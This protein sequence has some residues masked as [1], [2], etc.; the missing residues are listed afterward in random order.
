MIYGEVGDLPSEVGSVD[1]MAFL[2]GDLLIA[3][4]TNNDLWKIDRKNPGRTDGGYGRVG[5][6][7]S[8]LD[9]PTSMVEYDSDLI[10]VDSTDDSIYRVDPDDPDS[11]T[12]NYGLIGALSSI[13]EPYA[14]G[15]WG[16]VPDSVPTGLSLDRTHNRVDASWTAPAG[17]LIGYTVRIRETGTSSW[18]VE[19]YT[20][21]TSFRFTGLD[22]DTEYEVQVKAINRYGTTGFTAS[23]TVTTIATMVLSDLDL[24]NHDIDADALILAGERDSNG[25]VWGRSPRT[26]LGTL[27]DG[28][29]DVG[30]GA[31]DITELRIVS[32]NSQFTLF[33][34][35]ASFNIGTYFAEGGD[36]RELTI[37]WL[38]GPDEGVIS[39]TVATSYQ[40]GGNSFARFNIPSEHQSA[41]GG[42]AEGR[43][44]I[45][46]IAREYLSHNITAESTQSG[47][48]TS[49]SVDV[50]EAEIH[51]LT[52]ESRASGPILNEP[53]LDVF[54]LDIR[55]ESRAGGPLGEVTLDLLTP[56][57]ITARSGASGPLGEATLAVQES[58]DPALL[59]PAD[60]QIGLGLWFS[61]EL[62]EVINSTDTF[63]YSITGLPP[64]LSYSANTN[65]ITGRPTRIETD[66]I[67][68][69]AESTSGGTDYETSF[70]IDVIHRDSL[71]IFDY[72]W[73]I[74]WSD[75]EDYD[76]ADSEVTDIWEDVVE[77]FTVWRGRDFKAGYSVALASRVSV[78][79]KNDDRTYT[80][81]IDSRQL[82]PEG[83]WQ[84]FIDSHWYTLWRGVVD[85]V[86]E[87]TDRPGLVL[88]EISMLGIISNLV[89]TRISTSM[90]LD[91]DIHDLFNLALDAADV[92]DRW[93]GDLESTP[94]D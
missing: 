64:G 68:Y 80:P 35:N 14:M 85:D 86:Q 10:V 69:R 2:D 25:A 24:S 29:F 79:V 12:G 60:Q 70:E 77:E 28:H 34:S 88:V 13:L 62:D 19:I 66:E 89:K 57:L 67:I 53:E 61:L 91:T 56:S 75:N 83:R 26:V 55:L 31:D 8:D 76:D 46:A 58:T 27:E 72:R 39:F 1:A 44:F 7:F 92:E 87:V 4:G 15:I 50:V 54:D 36:G 16:E 33:D 5:S 93:K 51:E 47:A 59:H 42:I 71:H 84:V 41:I 17:D 9:D 32:S 38:L 20:S 73:Q 49:I 48:G 82:R 90:Q 94:R 30:H 21:E 43:Q 63:T 37:Y 11:T 18:T 40:S 45:F 74:N 52:L 65:R 81:Y 78:V 6:F 22:G 23:V 3:D